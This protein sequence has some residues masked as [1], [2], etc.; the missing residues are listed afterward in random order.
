MDKIY[1]NDQKGPNMHY[2]NA[3]NLLITV[4]S[5]IIFK[6]LL[7]NLQNIKL[8]STNYIMYFYFNFVGII[9]DFFICHFDLRFDS[10][11]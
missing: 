9:Y 5:E 2:A 4:E 8:F 6:K 3:Y 1:T 11:N 10:G 7:R